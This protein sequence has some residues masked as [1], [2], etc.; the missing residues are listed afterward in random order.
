VENGRE[1]PHGTPR[2]RYEDNMK[3]NL[4]GIVRMMLIGFFR[5]RDQLQAVVNR[6]MILR[7]T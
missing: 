2:R 3:I 5:G 4:K 7:V 6:L 1:R